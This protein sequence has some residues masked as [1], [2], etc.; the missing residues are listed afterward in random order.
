MGW[1]QQSGLGVLGQ[2]A[3]V[4]RDGG[5][6]AS[7]VSRTWLP[8]LLELCSNVANRGASNA[9]LGKAEAV[10]GLGGGARVTGGVS[11][12]QLLHVYGAAARFQLQAMVIVDAP[13]D[14]QSPVAAVLRAKSSRRRMQKVA[15]VLAT[16]QGS[17]RL[18]AACKMHGA[19]WV[20]ASGLEVLE[21]LEERHASPAGRSA[22][23]GS[24]RL[25]SGPAENDERPCRRQCT[26]SGGANFAVRHVFMNSCQGGL[27]PSLLTELAESRSGTPPPTP[28]PSIS[29]G[30]STLLHRP[31]A[32]PEQFSLAALNT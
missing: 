28:P 10:E 9:H 29:V 31:L 17:P 16:D 7:G 14:G 27:E 24:S 21:E 25:F 30:L 19:R 32:S 15:P 11:R 18:N 20:A 22:C 2:R 26:A 4:P 13:G 23:P 6:P 3:A 8:G 5:C 1:E 12:R